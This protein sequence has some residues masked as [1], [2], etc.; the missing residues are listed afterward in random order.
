MP[1][2]DVVERVIA[3]RKPPEGRM[4][5]LRKQSRVGTFPPSTSTPHWPSSRVHQEIYGTAVFDR[6]AVIQRRPHTG[7]M[8]SNRDNIFPP[9]KFMESE[10]LIF[11]TAF[12]MKTV[13]TILVHIRFMCLVFTN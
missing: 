2:H 7:L 8:P 12:G 3:P 1:P 13:I 11:P 6:A 10:V 5:S 4:C 9:G